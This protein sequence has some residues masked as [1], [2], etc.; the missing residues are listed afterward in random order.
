MAHGSV[1]DMLVEPGPDLLA[2]VRSE[3]GYAERAGLDHVV[4]E[5]DGVVLSMPVRDLES[6]DA[7]GIVDGCELKAPDL[8]S[9]FSNESQELEV[10]LDA[11]AGNLLVVPLPMD[12]AQPRAARQPVM[13]LRLRIR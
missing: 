1:L 11:V 4:D 8:L 5:S 10:H 13:P 3:L 9:A 6:A 7:G 12:L 2:I